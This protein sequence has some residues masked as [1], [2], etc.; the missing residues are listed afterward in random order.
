MPFW[1]KGEGRVIRRGLLQDRD[2]VLAAEARPFIADA[3]AYEVGVI[4]NGN[5]ISTERN[6]QQLKRHHH[7]V[8][9]SPGL[10]LPSRRL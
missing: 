6:M 9:Y 8:R 5:R 10:C 1:G 2:P 7:E 4:S 3:K